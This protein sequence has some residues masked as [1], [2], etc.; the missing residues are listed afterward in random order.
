MSKFKF[1]LDEP[2]ESDIMQMLKNAVFD[3]V[4]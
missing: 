2:T 4:G 1:E 3:S